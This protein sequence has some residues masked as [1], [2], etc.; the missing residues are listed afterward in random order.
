MLLVGGFLIVSSRVSGPIV[1]LTGIINRLADQDFAVEIAARKGEDEIGQ[2]QQALL[3][4]RE[5]GRSHQ[6]SI[7]ARAVEQET[8]A[9][10][11]VTVGQQCRAFDSQ[12]SRRKSLASCSASR[13]MSSAA[14][15][16][17]SSVARAAM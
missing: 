2:M 16:T 10:R 14:A 8:I 17:A 15:R 1:A 13:A 4:L 7:E 9:R 3:V 11:A 5:N 6:T 12:V